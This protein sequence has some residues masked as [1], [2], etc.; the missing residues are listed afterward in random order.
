MR[1]VEND[2]QLEAVPLWREPGVELEENISKKKAKKA[3]K[4]RVKANGA[5]VTPSRARSNA[6]VRDHDAHVLVCGGGDCKKRGSKDVRRALKEGLRAAG[7]NGEVRID[8]V[9]CLGLCKHGPNVVV[10]PGGSWYLGLGEEDVHELVERHLK[11]GEPV[12][13][14]AAGFRPRKKAKK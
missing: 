12:E 3:R 11:G 1:P 4:G 9:G 8:S 6:K 7:M 5:H 10:Y 13:R 14:L 2:S